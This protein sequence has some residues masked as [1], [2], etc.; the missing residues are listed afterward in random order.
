MESTPRLRTDGLTL[1]YDRTE[2]VRQLSLAIPDGVITTLVGPNGCG[3]S[4]LLRGLARLMKARSGGVYLDG[5]LIQRSSTRDV[6]RRLGLLRSGDDDRRHHRGRP[7][8]PGAVP[9]PVVLSTSDR[10]GPG[11]G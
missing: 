2:V 9:A 10:F 4:T 7:G 8:S 1:A 3:K 6:A 5:E 11:R